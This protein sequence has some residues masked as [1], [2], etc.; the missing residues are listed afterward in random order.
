MSEAG[1]TFYVSSKVP[2]TSCHL[3]LAFRS[4][5]TAEDLGKLINKTYFKVGP[6][7]PFECEI[8]PDLIKVG[9]DKELEAY[10]IKI[11]DPRKERVLRKFWDDNQRRKSGQEIFP[12]NL[13]V[14]L[15]KESKR[16][17]MD[18]FLLKEGTSFF[19]SEIEIK[20][21]ETKKVIYS[22]PNE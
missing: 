19:V 20:N 22:L 11:V 13:H 8:L 14:T 10:D 4:S 7:V 21:L 18:T 1:E 9:K 3:T 6:L 2:G 12:F 16:K 5:C 15:N 17:E